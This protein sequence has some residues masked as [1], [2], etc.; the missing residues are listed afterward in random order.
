MEI[1]W[2]LVNV[3]RRNQY[4]Y[5]LGKNS[6]VLFRAGAARCWLCEANACNSCL[7]LVS[8]VVIDPGLES[9]CCA[10]GMDCVNVCTA[11]SAAMLGK[12]SVLSVLT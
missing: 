3:K 1:F 4:R 8:T 7:A 11:M 6:G 12:S 2:C 9:P 10:T 5:S